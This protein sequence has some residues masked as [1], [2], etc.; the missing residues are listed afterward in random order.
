[1]KFAP[2]TEV[3]DFQ[4]GTQP[5]KREWSEK[6]L[7]GYIRMLQIRDFT[8]S[9][10]T[11][12]EFVK[13]SKKLKTCNTDDVLIGR[14]GA[15]IGKILTG[16]SGVY[17][18]AIVKTIPN[19]EVLNKK[20]LLCL[21]KSP[22]FQNFITTI[23]ARAAQAGFNKSDL[24][25]FIIPILPLNDQIRIAHLLGKVEG[26]IAQRKQG[27]QQLDDLLKSVFLE[28]FG[29][30]D[31]KYKKW[32]I[33]ALEVYT[34]IVSGVTKGKKYNG[35]DLIEVPY[36]RVANV[37]DGHFVLDEIK[38]IFVTQKEVDQY[39]L[40]SGDLL[41]T[42]GGDPDKLGRGSVWKNQIENCIHQNH[43]FRVRINERL[44]LNPYYLSALVGSRYG[45]LYF[46]KSAKQTTG[47]ASINSTQLKNFP[48]VIPSIELQNQFAAI[49]EKVESLKS[50]YRQNLTD[51]ETLYGALSQQAFSGE[52][53]LSRVR[54]DGCDDELGHAYGIVAATLTNLA[55]SND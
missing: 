32:T 18:V 30:R 42:E 39:L 41:L 13:N 4:G 48:V 2:I 38:T 11:A 53:D 22:S 10:K 49:V 15:S 20:F 43:I 26:L 5:P 37:Q 47:I 31:Q 3:C 14:Y 45:K 33:D 23:G 55:A 46:L 12:P 28:M 36:M 8:Q 6:P 17:N 29:F 34:E 51:L 24:T 9:E 52:L 54:W 16:Y 19:E 7:D 35:K 27:L 40:F 25:N 1:M 50:S 21:L 44:K